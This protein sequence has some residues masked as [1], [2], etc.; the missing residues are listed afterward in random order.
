MSALGVSRGTCCITQVNA[1]QCP[2][3]CCRC[4]RVE[5]TIGKGLVNSLVLGSKRVCDC[6]RNGDRTVVGMDTYQCRCHPHNCGAGDTPPFRMQ[7]PQ[8]L[9]GFI[10]FHVGDSGSRSEPVGWRQKGMLRLWDKGACRERGLL[11]QSLFVRPSRAQAPLD[12][13][14]GSGVS[15][16]KCG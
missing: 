6:Q 2:R 9:C 13:A 3:C 1:R 15:S 7:G 12:A 16:E 4:G 5:G 14:L 8:E 11:H 10:S